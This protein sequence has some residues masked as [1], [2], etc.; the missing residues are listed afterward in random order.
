VKILSQHRLRPPHAV[1]VPKKA[2]PPP[3][4]PKK[5]PIITEM[6]IQILLVFLEA[7]IE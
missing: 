3:V 4:R 7:Q 6:S 1:N 5:I 2:F